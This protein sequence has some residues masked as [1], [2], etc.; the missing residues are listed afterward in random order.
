MLYKL[1]IE[2]FLCFRE[3]QVIDLTASKT[4]ALDEAHFASIFSGAA[5][6]A[7][8]TVFIYG[9]NAS[10][11]STVVKA[12]SLLAYFVTNSY[13]DR[14][15]AGIICQPFAS[16]DMLEKPVR[17]AVEFGDV[18]NPSLEIDPKGTHSNVT[19]GA[20]RY[21]LELI[22]TNPKTVW[23]HMESLRQ[24]PNGAGKWK[25]V[26][27][28]NG[29]SLQGSKAF[30]LNNHTREIEKIPAVSSVI[31]TLAWFEHKASKAL[32]NAAQGIFSN[33]FLDKFDNDS[34]FLKYCLEF[35]QANPEALK[36]LNQEIQRL[37]VGIRQM[38]IF[39]GSTDSD[40]PF[41][42][43]EHSGLDS[44]I[45]WMMES[46]GTR[47][48]VRSFPRIYA[49]LQ[50]GGVAIMDELDQSLHLNLL[51][52]ILHWFHSSAENPDDAQLW[53]TC[54]SA[55]LMDD[56]L[57]EEI[58]FC[59][60]DSHGCAQ[61]YCLKEIQGVRR[62]ERFSKKYLGGVYGGIPNIG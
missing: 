28:R 49:A 42:T 34:P 60:K 55:P 38:S 18:M 17:L 33:T 51:T 26:F 23:V 61:A 44:P 40:G 37:D 16:S 59:E 43:F 32:A 6:K 4:A 52:E 12:M 56:L 20:W 11:K 39:S 19:Y 15:A 7:P 2:N 41:A 54:H 14:N 22:R 35:Y 13:D 50:A 46:Q 8:K 31:S 57:K 53:A 29:G 62:N 5:V 47:S 48:F 1:E 36:S 45:L 25:R 21:E 3:R 9:A 24:K 27:E 30:P 10:G 58:I